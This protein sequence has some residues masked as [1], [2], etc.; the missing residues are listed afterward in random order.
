M[1]YFYFKEGKEIYPEDY[2]VNAH[3]SEQEIKCRKDADFVIR[4]ESDETVKR[5]LSDMDSL[6]VVKVICGEKQDIMERREAA[7]FYY[8]A[9]SSSD[10]SEKERYT[11]VYCKLMMGAKVASDTIKKG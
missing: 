6:S 1:K 10:G 11:N 7:N 4:A 5:I 8:N 2:P 3:N 9:M